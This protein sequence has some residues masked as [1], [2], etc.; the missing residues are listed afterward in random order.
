MEQWQSFFV[1]QAGASA[2]LTGLLFVAV[3]INLNRILELDSTTNNGLAN[4]ALGA[5]ITLVSVLLSS[6]LLLVPIN[7]TLIPG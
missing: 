5:L 3:S 1:A 4:R 2:A 6:S 7:M